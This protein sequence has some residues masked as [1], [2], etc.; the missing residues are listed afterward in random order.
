MFAKRS[1]KKRTEE[2]ESHGATS[3]QPFQQTEPIHVA[4]NIYE[5]IVASAP[6]LYHIIQECPVFCCYL[7]HPDQPPQPSARISVPRHHLQQQALPAQHTSVSAVCLC[8]VASHVP[9]Q[10]PVIAD[11]HSFI[12]AQ[13]SRII[14]FH[15]KYSCINEQIFTNLQV[16]RQ[17]NVNKSHG[18]RNAKYKTILC[19]KF[20]KNGNCPYGNEC[21]FI[22]EISEDKRTSEKGNSDNSKEIENIDSSI[23]Q[24]KDGLQCSK[25]IALPEE[26]RNDARKSY[27][28]GDV[29]R[30]DKTR[31]DARESYSLRDIARLYGAR[32]EARE[33]YSLRDVARLYG[34][35]NNT[36][37]S[38]SFGD[39]AR[40]DK[41]RNNARESY[42]FGDVAR[43][44]K[45]RNN[46]RESYSFR[47]I[48]RLY[49][50]R[51]DARESYS[52]GDVARL[53]KTRNDANDTN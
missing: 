44:D 9:F 49:G 45:T 20:A 27:S 46:A 26:T 43:L 39:V 18:K 47:D 7:T 42:S 13:F 25:S 51:Y 24:V 37:E 31:N 6:F 23:I 2:N 34:A 12:H 28:F 40:L 11:D 41:T 8:P 22:H 32:N 5:N 38:Y 48:A 29:A 15:L 3:N 33:S 21:H 1:A 17:P 10:L 52:F 35:R 50:T 4:T 30:L 14:L 19:N 36:R 53:D 16:T